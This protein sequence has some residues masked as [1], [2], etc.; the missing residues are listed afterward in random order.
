MKRALLLM[1][2]GLA[3]L[4]AQAEPPRQE[5]ATPLRHVLLPDFS[6]LVK[7]QGPAVV[8]ILVAREARKESPAHESGIGSGS[9]SPPTASF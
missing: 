6:D 5:A 1:C 4:V 7:R 8:N 3:A 9:S 2:A